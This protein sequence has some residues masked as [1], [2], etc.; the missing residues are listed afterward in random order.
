M[1]PEQVDGGS[2]IDHRTDIYSLGLI[3]YELATGRIPFDDVSA[4]QTMTQRLTERPVSPKL[5]NPALSDRLAA[6]ILR[7]LE[8]DPANRFNDVTELL[9]AL[10]HKPEEG[11]TRIVDV[12]P[13]RASTRISKPWLIAATAAFVVL[14]A[15]AGLHWYRQT[16][17]EPPSNGKYIAVLPFRAI[18]PDPNLK[19]RAEGI[20][21]A[22][23]SRLSSLATLHPVSASALEQV[24]LNQSPEKIGR[25]VGANLLVQGTVQSQ[26]NRIKVN[27]SIANVEKHETIWNKSYDGLVE[28]LFTL[29]DRI[30]SDTVRALD[31]TPTLEERARA[32]PAPTQN[33]AAYDLYLKGRDILKNRRDAAGAKA[34]LDLFEQ[35]CRQDNSFALAWAGVADA[36]LLLYRINNDPLAA[37]KALAAA[38][39]ARNRNSNLPEVHFA[40]GSVYTA[41]G[42]N[43]EAVSEIKQA[44]QLSP[45]SDDGYIRLGRAYLAT[46]QKQEGLNALRKA[47]QLNKYYWRNHNQLGKALS[48]LGYTDEALKEFKEQVDLNPTNESGYNNV[49]AAYLQQA[50]WKKAIPEFQKAITIHPTYDE[51]SNLATAL[52]NLGRYKE[53][54][55]M[56]QQAVKLQPNQAEPVRNLA[57]AYAR[58]G[59][60]DQADRTFDRAIALLYEQLAVNPLNANATATLALCYAGKGNSAKAR[61]L[62][63]QAR[64]IDNA[65]TDLMYDEATV[66]VVDGRIP[67]ALKAL[68]RALENGYSF[69]SILIDPDMKVV[70]ESPGF[71]ALKKKFGQA[72]EARR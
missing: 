35:A 31:V 3:L 25:Q 14:A 51:Y 71:A 37:S 64:S 72:A 63:A 20:A 29:E 9:A 38:E 55:P 45:N 59:N 12:P 40:L 44:L 22:I 10:R 33:L 49:G 18:G 1:S 68:T 57:E 41:T 50:Q 6:L 70:R 11:L 19:Y 23:S 42:R 53:A 48:S 15:I 5:I 27:A 47:V 36:S 17:V 16:P 43:A 54:I 39:E 65:D 61:A 66:A 52:Y 56:Y 58:T 7:C 60:K 2:A 4:F 34:A 8:Q 24:S 46:G 13:T 21:D 28:D 67:D 69:Q 30:S 62:I 26:G 32:A